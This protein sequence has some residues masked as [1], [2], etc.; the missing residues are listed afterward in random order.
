MN[1]KLPLL[2]STF[3]LTLFF[4]GV[5]YGWTDMQLVMEREEIYCTNCDNS[6]VTTDGRTFDPTKFNLVITIGEVSRGA[7][8]ELWGWIG[9]RRACWGW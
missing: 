4:S 8:V 6:T 2:I 5:I 7:L 3:W 1:F 9:N